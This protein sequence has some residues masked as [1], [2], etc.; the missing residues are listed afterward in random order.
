V[1][2]TI[3]FHKR[4]LTLQRFRKQAGALLQKMFTVR[5][6]HAGWP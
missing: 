6:D 5:F 3:A 2:R 4:A 1:A